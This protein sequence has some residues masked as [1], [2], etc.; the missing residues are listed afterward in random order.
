MFPWQEL[1]IAATD[2][3]GVIRRAYATRLKITNPDDDR[4]GFMRLRAAYE[5]ALTM[6]RRNAA[7]A[8]AAEV[9]V[10]PQPTQDFAAATQEPA[11]EPA[12]DD[13]QALAVQNQIL[14]ALAARNAPAAAD[15]LQDAI[16]KGVLPLAVEIGLTDRL[17]NALVTDGM[18]D[19]ET[20]IR[21]ARQ[22]GWYGAAGL[23]HAG[24]PAALQRLGARID[25]ELW[26]RSLRDRA[27]DWRFYVGDQASA[28]ARLLLGC[29]PFYFSRVLP[30]NPPLKA[31][32]VQL[33]L[34]FPWI[35]RHLDLP[36]LRAIERL[37]TGRYTKISSRAVGIIW[38][39]T[40]GAMVVLLPLASG[41]GVAWIG[42]YWV[43]VILVRM[44]II[45][46]TQ[47]AR[48]LFLVAIAILIVEGL[49]SVVT[50]DPVGRRPAARASGN[51]VVQI[52]GPSA[53]PTCPPTV[54]P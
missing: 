38:F 1:G 21:I 3:P 33:T 45:K 42:V 2:D 6:A 24:N 51:C 49:F 14:A 40:I 13:A 34:H 11:S 26:L 8:A 39:F 53:A 44:K 12:H 10:A 20:L 7:P 52:I 32:L 43:F 35:A 23:S 18:I 31:L 46:F 37:V 29:G 54:T 48:T 27:A 4:D 36:R 28:A 25:A 19:A 15:T 30:P 22:F 16:A 47:S 17:L 41:T 50:A 9:P 5:A